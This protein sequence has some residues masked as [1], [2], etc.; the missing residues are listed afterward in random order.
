MI[1]DE[2]QAFPALGRQTFD[3]DG[4][5]FYNGDIV[6]LEVVYTDCKR[7]TCDFKSFHNFV[8]MFEND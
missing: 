5:F 4:Y 3:D 6:I 1:W 7:L 8:V 2:N